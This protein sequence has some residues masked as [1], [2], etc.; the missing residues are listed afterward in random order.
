MHFYLDTIWNRGARQNVL[1]L[2][3]DSECHWVGIFMGFVDSSAGSVIIYD[4]MGATPIRHA[5]HGRRDF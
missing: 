3:D 1:A 5:L 4:P 2:K